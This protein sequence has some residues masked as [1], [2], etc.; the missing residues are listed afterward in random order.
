M[1]A[2]FDLEDQWGAERKRRFPGAGEASKDDESLAFLWKAVFH[3]LR[4]PLKRA[5][6]LA[7]G[8]KNAR[9]RGRFRFPLAE[10]EA[11]ATLSQLADFQCP[12]CALCNPCNALWTARQRTLG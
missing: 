6:C 2:F 9:Y 7:P 11:L 8:M 12:T 4:N 3:S 5:S 1:L 10:A